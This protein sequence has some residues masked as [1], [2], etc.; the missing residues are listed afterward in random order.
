MNQYAVKTLAKLIRQLILSL[1]PILT[2]LIAAKL[3]PG[4][5]DVIGPVAG[6]LAAY[7]VPIAVWVVAFASGHL[8]GFADTQKFMMALSVAGVSADEVEALVKNPDVPT[9][10]VTT[11][12]SDV[13]Q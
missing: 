7:S 6:E 10:S 2:P 9:P 11:P 8:S 13:P 3:G 12:K 4:F 1:T 5:A